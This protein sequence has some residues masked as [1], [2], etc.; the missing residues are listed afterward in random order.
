MNAVAGI[1]TGAIT[2]ATKTAFQATTSAFSLEATITSNTGSVPYQVN[3]Q[4][5]PRLWFAVSSFSITAAQAVTQ[6]ASIAQTLD[7]VPNMNAKGIQNS[8]TEALA[9]MGGYIYTWLEEPN[10]P[11]NQ[12]ATVSVNLI[13]LD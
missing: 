12:T 1:G 11:A 4:R 8:K 7:I 2:N 13:E 9:A 5:V 6:L 3:R 10:M